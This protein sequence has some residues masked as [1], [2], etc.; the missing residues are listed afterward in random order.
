MPA[1]EL[2]ATGRIAPSD[3]D[4]LGEGFFS[5][6]RATPPKATETAH[7]LEFKTWEKP[8]VCLVEKDGRRAH[9]CESLPWVKLEI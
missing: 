7:E 5:F 3:L 4:I 6:Q 8:R 9:S 1:S 2:G